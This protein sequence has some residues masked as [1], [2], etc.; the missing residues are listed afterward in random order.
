MLHDNSL[1]SIGFRFPTTITAMAAPERNAARHGGSHT[2][3]QPS[4]HERRFGAQ[5]GNHTQPPIRRASS[6]GA[7]VR[8]RV[9]LGRALVDG[10]TLTARPQLTIEPAT[11][12]RMIHLDRSSVADPPSISALPILAC[13]ELYRSDCPPTALNREYRKLSVTE[14]GQPSVL[15]VSLVRRGRSTVSNA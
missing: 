5:G 12:L 11:A 8:I 10:P 4:A 6:E 15:G 13:H 14:A 3:S 1:V 7:R 9:S 2:K